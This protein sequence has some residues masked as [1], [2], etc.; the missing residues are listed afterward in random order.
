VGLTTLPC[1]KENV[2][3]PPRNSAGFC[4]GGL[5]PK[6]GCGTK[7][8]RR[9]HIGLVHCISPV[10][11]AGEIYT[12]G[13]F[14]GAAQEELDTVSSFLL[15]LSSD[16]GSLLTYWQR[17]ICGG[18]LKACLSLINLF[19]QK[20]AICCIKTSIPAYFT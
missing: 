2:E 8:R 18:V 14:N 15:L 12:K 11:V 19:H 9:V 7:E 20:Q 16:W 3:K 13:R 4:G 1:K 10:V 6:L 17:R 5:G